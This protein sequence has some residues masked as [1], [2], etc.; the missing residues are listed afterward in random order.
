MLYHFTP[1]GVCSSKFHAEISDEGFIESLTVD[2][3]CSG[4][5][6]GIGKLAQGRHISEVISLLTGI[7]C[8]RKATSCPDQIAKMLTEISP[9]TPN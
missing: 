1:K 8:G 7:R 9:L 2:G 3:G 5:S 4:N 6:K